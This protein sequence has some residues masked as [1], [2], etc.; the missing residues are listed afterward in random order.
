[1]N[2]SSLVSS[3]IKRNLKG[4]RTIAT[5]DKNLIKKMV[6]KCIRLLNKKEY[7]LDLP[8]DATDIALHR[9]SIVDKN[10]NGATYGGRNIIQI[11]LSYWQHC[12]GFPHYECEYK[13]F[14]SHPTIGGAT[15]NNL[16]ENLWLTVA[17]EVSHHIQYRY[18]PSIRRFKNT[19]SKPHGDCFKAIYGYLRRDLVNPIL[20]GEA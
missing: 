13:A 11:N 8:K 20:K 12:K 10:V 15:V 4:S 5:A 17:H 1:M 14:D 3:R 18:C 2:R 9:L 19:Y 16:E 6:R 7:E